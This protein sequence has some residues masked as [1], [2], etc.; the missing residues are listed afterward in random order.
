[1]ICSENANEFPLYLNLVNQI[2]AVSPTIV[3]PLR[4]AYEITAL[5]PSATIVSAFSYMD[6][7]L[8][9]VGDVIR[10]EAQPPGK[11]PIHL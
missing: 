4:F 10:G 8:R 9:A 5:H 6:T 11:L 1:M 3:I 7:S 2:S